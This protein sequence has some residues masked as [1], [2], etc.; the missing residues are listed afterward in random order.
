MAQGG[1]GTGRT[2]HRADMAQG[3][4][5]TGRTW[6]RA[7][8]AQGRHG[9][10]YLP[11]GGSRDSSRKRKSCAR[12]SRRAAHARPYSCVPPRALLRGGGGPLNILMHRRDCVGP[13]P[14]VATCALTPGRTG[15]EG[16]GMVWLRRAIAREG[17]VRGHREELAGMGVGRERG[18]GWQGWLRVCACAGAGGGGGG[19]L[20]CCTE[21]VADLRSLAHEKQPKQLGQVPV[22]AAPPPIHPPAC[23]H[24]LPP[25]SWFRLR[26]RHRPVRLGLAMPTNALADR[27]PADNRARRNAARS[28]GASAA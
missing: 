1:H 7:D 16:G 14:V 15:R 21:Q 19:G 9:R 2:W 11:A 20:P 27:M 3:G 5:G 24:R 13:D 25:R 12:P 22:P 6:H 28:G 26:R 4:H 8:M 10:G 23:P 17:E 18:R